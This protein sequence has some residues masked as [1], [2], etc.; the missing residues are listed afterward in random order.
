VENPFTAFALIATVFGY[1]V[2]HVATTS[3]NPGHP[4]FPMFLAF[5]GATIGGAW[6]YLT[7]RTREGMQDRA[8][9]FSF[10]ASWIGLLVYV[11]LLVASLF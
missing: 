4:T 10:F 11:G 7:K 2:V 8:F 6:G 9:W 3:L 1:S 5:V